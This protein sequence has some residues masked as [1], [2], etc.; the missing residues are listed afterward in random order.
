M[1]ID[2]I[3]L[4]ILFAATSVTPSFC[5]SDLSV[6]MSMYIEEDTTKD[7]KEMVDIITRFFRA[8]S[9]SDEQGAYWLKEDRK[10][11]TYPYARLLNSMKS[12]AMKDNYYY[13]PTII[14]IVTHNDSV[15]TVSI[16]YIHGESNGTGKLNCIQKIVIKNGKIGSF[17]LNNPTKNVVKEKIGKILFIKERGIKSNQKQIDSLQKFNISLAKF[18]RTDTLNFVYVVAKNFAGIQKMRESQYS[19]LDDYADIL[20]GEAE[21][22]NK[23]LY[24]GNG[25]FYYPHELV[26]LYTYHLFPLTKNS[27]FDEG[28]ATYLGGSQ[29][30][31]LSWHLKELKKY[32]ST[33]KLNLG[34]FDDLMFTYSITNIDYA[35]GGLICKLTYERKGFEGLKI[36]FEAGETN[37]NAYTAIE[38]VL[39]VKKADLNA[40]LRKELQKY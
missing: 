20:Q 34:E 7:T 12:E 24:V 15:K 28:L 38:K 14:N 10:Y 27:I 13:K 16:G 32:V 2:T 26:H 29:S 1:K 17:L 19:L 11:L 36:L 22:W 35:V 6:G 25:S 3:F 21:P 31:S 5:Q 23:I 9:F 8:K 40:F 37:E 39:G 33:D 30:R 18:L 4:S